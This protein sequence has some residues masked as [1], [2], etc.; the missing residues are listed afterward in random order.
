M[1]NYDLHEKQDIR[2]KSWAPGNSENLW[3][4]QKLGHPKISQ[5]PGNSGKLWYPQKQDIRVIRVYPGIQEKSYVRKSGT[6]Q[7][8]AHT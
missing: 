5:I 4:P 2:K 1:C 3:Y 8:F 7:K 6:S